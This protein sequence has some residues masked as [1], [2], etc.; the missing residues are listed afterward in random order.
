MTGKLAARSATFLLLLVA[1]G[2]NDAGM[3][4]PTTTL[5]PPDSRGPSPTDAPSPPYPGP[6]VMEGADAMLGNDTF[7]LNDA[8][9]TGDTLIVS[10]SYSGGCRAHAFTLVIAALFTQS[11]PVQLPAVLRHEA[12]GDPCEAFPTET[13]AFDLALVRTRY[14]ETYGPGPGRVALQIEG[15]PADRL[16]YAFTA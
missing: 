6:V 4:A 8:T 15:V 2:C 3:P 9:I 11:S 1:T 13:Y 12:N 7:V 5:V 14:R 16:V 10:V